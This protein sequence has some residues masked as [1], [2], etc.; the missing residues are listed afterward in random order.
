MRTFI[1]ISTS[2]EINQARKASAYRLFDL[3][4]SQVITQTVP[5]ISIKLFYS[6]TLGD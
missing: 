4:A 6:L 5:N 2:A 1:I 3:V